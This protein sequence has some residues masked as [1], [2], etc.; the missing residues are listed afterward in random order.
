MKQEAES[1]ATEVRASMRAEE[2][3]NSKLYKKRC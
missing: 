1:Y 3:E 2:M